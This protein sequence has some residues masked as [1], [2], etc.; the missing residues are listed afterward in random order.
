M[1]TPENEKSE[2]MPQPAPDG[3]AAAQDKIMEDNLPADAPDDTEDSGETDGLYVHFNFVVDKGQQPLRIDKFITNRVQN[4]SRNR[5]QVAAEA[6]SIHV[7]G[8]PVKSNYKI[9]PFDK[10]TILLAEPPRDTE[11][12]PQNIP[13]DIIY[14]DDWL[15]V[16]NKPAGMVV[17]PGYNNYDSTLVNALVYHFDQLPTANGERRPGLVHRIDKDTSGLLVIAKDELTM[18]KLARQFF[19]HTIERSYLALVWGVPEPPAGTV[20]AHLARSP[21]DRR[22]MAAFPDGSAGKHAIT[23]YE[24]LESFHQTAL[25]R[26][27]LET[28][29]THQIRAHMKYI[30]HPLFNDAT[31]EGD[32]VVYGPQFTRFKQFIKNCFELCPRQALHA[33]SLGFTHPQTGQHCFFEVPLPDDMEALVAKWRQY[34]QYYEKQD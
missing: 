8:K 18:S 13:L 32:K 24:T 21:K 2:N 27:T 9:K 29:R 4:A 11:V 26:C 28:G 20:N 19:D 22:V 16:V 6:G 10:I 5:V 3:H 17:H 12:K 15:L 25:I 30:G 7:N 14:E 34:A 23:H 1:L 33:R 31:Y